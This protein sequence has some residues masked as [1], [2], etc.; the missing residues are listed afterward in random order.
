LATQATFEDVAWLL[1][2]GEYPTP[3][4]ST[5]VRR[6]LA[7]QA[8][9]PDAVVAALRLFPADSH[10]IDVLRTGVS[11]LGSFDPEL[12]DRTHEANVRKAIRITSRMGALV[13]AAWRVV[14]GAQPVPSFEGQRS[15]AWRFLTALNDA[16]PPDWQVAAMNTVLILYAEHEFNA[17]TFAARV[18][19]STLSDVYAAVTSAL[20]TLKGPLHGGAN[21]GAMKVLGEVGEPA[22]AAAWARGKLA[23]KEKVMGFGH[24]IYRTG[25]S[26]VPV[27]RDLTRRIG[28]T[29]NQPHWAATCEA[30]EAAMS[31]EKGLCANVDLYAAPVLH[32]MG[33]PAALNTPIFACA[34]ATGW[35]AH[36]IEQLDHNRLIR[37]RSVYTGPARRTPPVTS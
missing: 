21:E 22:N 14:R 28:Q 6:E 36:V 23:R 9:L 25:D 31:A 24:R 2:R 29:V 30:L 35:C 10:P 37:P 27:M 4:E 18:T 13:P 17:S 8:A 34:R 26:R 1:L 5:D 11:M 20:G 33:I 3:Q 12:S 16:P 7:E 15:F 19:A 32:M